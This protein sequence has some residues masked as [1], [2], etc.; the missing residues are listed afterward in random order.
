MGADGR[1]AGW[2]EPEESAAESYLDKTEI[3]GNEQDIQDSLEIT[4]P[5]GKCEITVPVLYKESTG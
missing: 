3:T 2:R 4:T 1:M 5:E